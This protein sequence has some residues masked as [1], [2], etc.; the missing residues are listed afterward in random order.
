MPDSARDDMPDTA[1]FWRWVGQSLRPVVGW[2]L[3]AIGALAL[4]VG[5]L[6]VSRE[7]IVAKQIP[8][9]IS[10]GLGGLALLIIG[11]VYLGTEDVRRDAARLERL[12]GLVEELHQALLVREGGP[13]PSELAS[14]SDSDLYRAF[15]M[16]QSTMATTGNGA[17]A[18]SVGGGVVVLP[19]GKSYHRPGCPMVEGKPQAE[20]VPARSA[21]S[22][23]LEPCRLCEPH[24]VE[25]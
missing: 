1:L 6:G 19:Q 22:K 3:T 5:Y 24:L 8:F 11:A 23:G 12:E 14:V 21:T 4:L 2:V 15:D 9:L 20:V 18:T 16:D 25:A 13:T 17:N 7:A 10:G